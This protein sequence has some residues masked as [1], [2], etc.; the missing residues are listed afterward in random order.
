MYFL[1]LFPLIDHLQSRQIIRYV[2]FLLKIKKK[3][4]KKKKFFFFFFFFFFLRILSAANVIF[5]GYFDFLMAEVSNSFCQPCLMIYKHYDVQVCPTCP[6][7]FNT[8][9]LYSDQTS[10]TTTNCS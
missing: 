7:Y 1:F 9:S 6:T 8:A 5:N 2:D 3:K 10:S 4:K